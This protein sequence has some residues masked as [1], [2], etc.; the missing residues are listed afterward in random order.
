[1]CQLSEKKA[2]PSE[3]RRVRLHEIF[4]ALYDHSELTK[5]K[6]DDLLNEMM[7][8]IQGEGLQL[9]LCEFYIGVARAYAA[10]GAFKEAREH[11][12][13]SEEYW[14]RY[15][16]EEH[17]NVEGMK[18]LWRELDLAEKKAAWGPKPREYYFG[19]EDYDELD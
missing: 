8:I 2:W 1:M 7:I 11:A 17:E 16:S 14:I 4:Q 15:G 19:D 3:V 5:S 9:Q 6:V 13:L 10:V 12:A 18:D